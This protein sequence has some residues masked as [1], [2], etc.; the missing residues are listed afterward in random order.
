MQP[1][2]D[3]NCL[4]SISDVHIEFDV[5]K[6]K[7]QENS[8]L[9]KQIDAFLEENWKRKCEQ[10]SRLYNASKFRLASFA[11]QSREKVRIKI[12]ITSYKELLGKSIINSVLILVSCF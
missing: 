6:F 4:C 2:K 11:Y 3:D 7:R 8:T 5:E 1:L 9:Q 10:N 12:G